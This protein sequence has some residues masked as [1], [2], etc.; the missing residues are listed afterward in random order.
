MKLTSKVVSWG[1]RIGGISPEKWLL[2]TLKVEREGRENL[3][4]YKKNTKKKVRKEEE[5]GSKEFF[6][7]RKYP[8][9]RMEAKDLL[10]N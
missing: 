2:F 6:F 5:G 1:R 4:E 9:P 8:I 10:A 7:Q 3:K